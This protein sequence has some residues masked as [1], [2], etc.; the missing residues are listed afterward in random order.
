MTTAKELL[1]AATPLPWTWLIDTYEPP[2]VFIT[3]DPAMEQEPIVD[4]A[5]EPDAA[6]IV[7][8]VNRLP[9]SLAAEKALRMTVVL[10][11]GCDRHRGEALLDCEV[12]ICE[13]ARVAL[14]RLRSEVPT[15]A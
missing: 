15:D 1:D 14:A 6:L 7:Y 5:N 11:H 13:Q 9:A 2:L 4:G 3:N 12:T 10:W 8:A